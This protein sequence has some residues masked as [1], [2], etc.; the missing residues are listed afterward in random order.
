MEGTDYLFLNACIVG[1]MTKNTV[2]PSWERF[3]RFLMGQKEYIVTNLMLPCSQLRGLT[4]R[5]L[6]VP[7]LLNRRRHSLRPTC[8][9]NQ[10]SE[11][12]LV[13]A[14]RYQCASKRDRCLVFL[15]HSNDVSSTFCTRFRFCRLQ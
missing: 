6:P 14:F 5:K 2:N 11:S 3:W 12:S 10:L 9:K 4:A 8:E 15:E 13:Q 7:R 1:T